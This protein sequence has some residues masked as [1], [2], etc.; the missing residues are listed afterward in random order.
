MTV[1]VIILFLLCLAIWFTYI[2]TY[3]GGERKLDSFNSALHSHLLPVI[4]EHNIHTH[5]NKH[6]TSTTIAPPQKN[7]AHF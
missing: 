1:V 2:Q 5:T 3:V 7:V 6:S 4:Q